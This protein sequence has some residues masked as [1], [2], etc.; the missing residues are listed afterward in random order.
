[1]RHGTPREEHE[2]HL[3]HLKH[4]AT[5]IV[6]LVELLCNQ[7]VIMKALFIQDLVD[8]HALRWILFA[9]VRLAVLACRAD[10]VKHCLGLEA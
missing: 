5:V 1:M 3:G 10:P 6:M 8:W 2:R 4:G 9:R 7:A